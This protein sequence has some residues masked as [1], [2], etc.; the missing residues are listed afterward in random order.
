MRIA[1]TGATGFVGTR[2]LALAREGGVAVSALTRRPRD[3]A[4]GV[5]WVEGA[6]DDAA[7]L[8]R[9]ATGADAV[10][11]VAGV[12]NAPDRA[13][14]VAG[15][16]EGTRNILSA[17]RDAGVA[18]FVH[19]SSLAAREPG[20]SEYGATKA[21]AE[22]LVEGSGLAW[23][24]VRPPA[25]YGPGDREMLDLFRIARLGVALLP[26]G[27][28]MSAIHVDDL[29]RLLLTLAKAPAAHRIYEVDDGRAG[30]WSHAAFARAIGDALGKR[31]R[32]I[33]L[34]RRLL[35]LGA[36]VDSLVRGTG[37]KLTPDRVSYFCHPD[38]VADPLKRPPPDLWHPA[39]ATPDGLAAT[40]A[41]YRANGLL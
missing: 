37:A 34:P 31:V 16:V 13:G 41:W 18:R 22:G 36:R 8:L 26:P 40:A 30:G 20:L 24:M 28:R 27:G 32:P 38:W 14:F 29:S 15:N 19:V 6:L 9:L 21:D 23:D 11:H 33:A 12:V 3:D 5:T 4:E 2:L 17:A 1:V 7:A 25:I 10:V 39:I 35:N